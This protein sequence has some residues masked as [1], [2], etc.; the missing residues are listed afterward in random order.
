MF[1]T[2]LGIGND[3]RNL[4][5]SDSQGPDI[6]T[7]SIRYRRVAKCLLCAFVFPAVFRVSVRGIV[8]LL[9]PVPLNEHYPIGGSSSTI[10][11]CKFQ[12]QYQFCLDIKEILR[13]RAVNCTSKKQPSNIFTYQD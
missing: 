11:L 6:I 12:L 7:F 5:K 2:G 1:H 8:V 10:R 13:K 4:L 9:S 3:F